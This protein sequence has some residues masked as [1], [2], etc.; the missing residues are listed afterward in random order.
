[1]GE[2]YC[3]HMSTS[4][5][6]QGTAVQPNDTKDEPTG[7][8]SAILARSVAQLRRSSSQTLSAVATRAGVSPAYL[9]QMESGAANPTLRT[10]A[11]IA[12]ALDCTLAELFG[13]STR[14]PAGSPFPPR[15]ARA[16]LLATVAGHQGV[17]DLTAEGGA[18]LG[19]RLLHAD[20]GDHAD[21]VHHGGEE[22][23]VVLSGNCRIRVGPTARTLRV[24]DSCHFAAPDEHQFTDPS[25]DLLMLVVL[26]SQE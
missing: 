12:G 6:A 13:G 25:N 14:E 20:V 10:L 2:Y 22:L 17:W 3:R 7:E 26:T 11:Q 5:A 23:V 21:P 4:R 18:R 8:A 24:G 19:S 16:P 9:S 15:F 1:M